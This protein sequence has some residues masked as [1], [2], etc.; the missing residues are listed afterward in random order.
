MLE[1]LKYILPSVIV[2]ATVFF[3]LHFQYKQQKTKERVNVFLNNRKTIL[4]IRLQAYERLIL[5]LER[6]SA[7]ALIMR[8]QRSGLTVFELQS[9]LLKIIRQEFDH[10]LS[11]QLYVSNDAWKL[12]RNA[13]ENVVKIINSAAAELDPK[14]PAMHLSKAILEESRGS[15]DPTAKAIRFIKEEIQEILRF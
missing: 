2:A 8:T 5:F 12:V 14:R 1:I 4:P 13:R 9:T 10:N 15:D 6:I 3:I 7:E 11:Q